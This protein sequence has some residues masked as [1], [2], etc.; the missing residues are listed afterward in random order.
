MSKL[1][2]AEDMNHCMYVL[3][4]LITCTYLHS[5]IDCKNTDTGV[6][7]MPAHLKGARGILDQE[8]K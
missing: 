2:T 6:E 7:E 5:T 1:S 3:M 4:T 8:N